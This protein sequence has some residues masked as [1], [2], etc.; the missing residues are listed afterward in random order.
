LC[1]QSFSKEEVLLLIKVLKTRYNIDR[2]LRLKKD[3]NNI[4]YV[5]YIREGSM[6]KLRTIVKPF[7]H[8]KFY[9][10]IKLIDEMA[11]TKIQSTKTKISRAVS[12]KV[13]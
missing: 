8:P 9:F 4:G 3:R 10:K 12:K 7:M 6:E 5:I 1:T 13:L 11:Q 2:N